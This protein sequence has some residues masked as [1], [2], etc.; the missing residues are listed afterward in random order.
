M[1]EEPATEEPD[2]E[3]APVQRDVSA[4]PTGQPSDSD[5]GRDDKPQ[6]KPENKDNQSD[7]DSKPDQEAVVKKKAKRMDETLLQAF[8]YFDRSG[9]AYKS[10]FPP[11]NCL[12]STK[13]KQG[14]RC[15][16][17]TRTDMSIMCLTS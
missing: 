4:E 6:S 11:A 10:Q 7:K 13:H 15:I 17:S 3:E 12:S 14:T 5:N 8:R 2:K 16:A 9:K 1:Q